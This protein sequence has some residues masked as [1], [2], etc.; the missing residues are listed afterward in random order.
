MKV[1]I[2]HEVIMKVVIAHEVIVNEVIAQEVTRLGT[3]GLLYD[4]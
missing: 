4:L 2:A 3:L 1:V